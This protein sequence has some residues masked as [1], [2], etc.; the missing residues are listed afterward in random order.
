MSAARVV[1]RLLSEGLEVAAMRAKAG[2]RYEAFVPA[3]NCRLANGP[4][5]RQEISEDVD[6]ARGSN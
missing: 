2:E 3:L 6:R 1:R 5:L 4:K